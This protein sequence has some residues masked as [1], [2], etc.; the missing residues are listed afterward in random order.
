M[1]KPVITLETLNEKI[2]KIVALLDANNNGYRKNFNIIRDQFSKIDDM[3]KTQDNLAN[4]QQIRISKLEDQIREVA[5]VINDEVIYYKDR[6]ET[7]PNLDMYSGGFK[8]RKQRKQ[9]KSRRKTSKR[10][11]KI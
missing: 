2:T 4:Q 9:R 5:T 11:I 8:S 1:D 10:I 3:I 6:R 7:P